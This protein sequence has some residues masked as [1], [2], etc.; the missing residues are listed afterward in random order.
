MTRLEQ[1]SIVLQLGNAM[2]S[3]G[4]WMGETHLQKGTF[5]LEEMTGVPLGFKFILYKHGPF[6]FDLREFLS[7]MDSEG[8]LR[9]Q[10]AQPPYG[11]S[12]EE[13]DMSSSLLEQ[14]GSAAKRYRAQ[15]AFVANSLGSKN[16]SELERIATALYVTKRENLAGNMRVNR[17]KELKPH[18]EITKIQEAVSEFDEMANTLNT[19]A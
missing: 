5:F 18:I 10:A 7:Y 1:A 11:P 17:I 6:S 14:Y 9:W 16:V 12:I 13:G 19:M 4:S 3:K 2:R 15:I 8:F